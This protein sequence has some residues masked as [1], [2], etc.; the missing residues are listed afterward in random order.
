MGA[1]LQTTECSTGLD[2]QD[3]FFRLCLAPHRDGWDRWGTAEGGG[4]DVSF[5][6]CS[7]S[8]WITG[9]VMHGGLIV[10]KLLI[11]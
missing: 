6:L 5:L 4:I 1:G 3:G 2:V 9:F 7:F 10:L 11:W 8:T